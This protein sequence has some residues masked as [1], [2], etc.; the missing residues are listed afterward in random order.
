MLCVAYDR[1]T[2]LQAAFLQFTPSLTDWIKHLPP[3]FATHVRT[4][5]LLKRYFFSI[6]FW[7]RK[8][9]YLFIT[10]IFAKI[11]SI[12]SKRKC[13][14]GQ[15]H[16]C[17]SC[18]LFVYGWMKTDWLIAEMVISGSPLDG[19]LKTTKPLVYNKIESILSY[20]YLSSW[21]GI[22]SRN[23]DVDHRYKT[24]SAQ[25]FIPFAGNGFFG[26]FDHFSILSLW[27]VREYY[28]R[29]FTAPSIWNHL[30]RLSAHVT[31]P[32]TT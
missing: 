2:P 6:P 8:N 27:V 5:S 25:F 23:Y 31:L 29:P 7:L 20:I 21:S 30:L 11:T 14:G 17:Q 19:I 22:L 26:V 28:K 12:K 9:V 32:P 18:W 10:I 24:V 16:P 1:K 3:Y 13:S 15:S 4:S